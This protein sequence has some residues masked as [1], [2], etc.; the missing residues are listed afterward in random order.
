MSHLELILS[1]I[2]LASG[3]GLIITAKDFYKLRSDIFESIDKNYVRKD[4]H[5]TDVSSLKQDIEDLKNDIRDMSDRL[6]DKID[7]I[8]F[9]VC[10]QYKDR[11]E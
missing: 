7:K 5:N 8:Y 2:T 9:L 11:G 1:I 10:N 3:T 6:S 4:V